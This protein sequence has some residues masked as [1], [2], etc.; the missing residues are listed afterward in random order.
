VTDPGRTAAG[1]GR[2]GENGVYQS[3]DGS[4]E[5]DDESTGEGR[6]SGGRREDDTRRE[7][8]KDR[9]SNAHGR[10][11]PYFVLALYVGLVAVAVAA[12]L[13]I[14]SFV[15]DLR[16]PRFLFIVPFPATPLGF[17]AYGG[18]TVALVLGVPLALVSYVSRELD[19][20]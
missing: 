9:E 6:E 10:S 20:G 1:N 15:D 14:G 12:G 5:S 17:A 2:D 18:L 8:D 19:D 3:D 16:P 4:I 11:G 13:L 7:D